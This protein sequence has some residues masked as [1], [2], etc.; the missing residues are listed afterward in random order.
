MTKATT[1]ANT[2]ELRRFEAVVAVANV[3]ENVMNMK[4]GKERLPFL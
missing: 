1:L 3:I 2:Q 4:N